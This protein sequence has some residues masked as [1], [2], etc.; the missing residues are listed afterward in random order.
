M[1]TELATRHLTGRCPTLPLLAAL[2]VAILLS[3]G[4]GNGDPFQ[5]VRI[6]GKVTYEDGSPIPVDGM[7]ATFVPIGGALDEKT[8]IRPGMTTID[9]A[10]GDFHAVSSHAFNDGLPPGKYKVTLLGLAHSPLPASLVPLEYSDPART[11]LEVDTA[12]LPFLLKV[13][14]PVG[15]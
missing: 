9:R 14:K 7:V 5:Y 1:K 4:C 10:T 12:S 6:T 13:R 2:A 3:A 15:R 8:H 11:P